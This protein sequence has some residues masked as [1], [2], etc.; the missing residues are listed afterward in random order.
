VETR[1]T[2]KILE[3]GLAKRRRGLGA[4]RFERAASHGWSPSKVT[5]AAPALVELPEL[6]Y[7]PLR[8]DSPGWIVTVFDN[9]ENTYEQVMA[10]LMIAT[11]C[12][13]EEA[14]MEAWEI[15]HMGKSVVHHAAEDE[16]REAAD[17]ISKIG[18]K[19]LVT[20]E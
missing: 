20:E 12:T 7:E 5:G 18:I 8:Q 9:D 6:D 17:V 4:W 14:Y 3:H 16:C 15:D 2:K 19:V 11:G 1:Y 10:I 13:A